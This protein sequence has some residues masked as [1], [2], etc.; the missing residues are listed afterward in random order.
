MRRVLSWRRSVGTVLTLVGLAPG[1]LVV[2][3]Q[4]VLA[5]AAAAMEQDSGALPVLPQQMTGSAAGLPSLLPATQLPAVAN[6]SGG[7]RAEVQPPKGAVPQEDRTPDTTQADTPESKRLPGGVLRAEAADA[8]LLAVPSLVDVYP[9]QGYLVD[10][11]TPSLRAWGQSNNG[12]YAMSYSFKICDVESMSGTGCTS[13]GDVAGNKN[14]WTVP[15][16]KLAW[17]KQYWWT[18]TVRDSY[19]SSTTTS[20]VLTFT[21]GVRQPAITSNLA[22]SGVAG[23]EFN[24]QNGNYTSTFTDLEVATA[25]PPLSVVRTY[26]GLDPRTDGMFGPGWSTRWDMKIV[27]EVRGASTSALVTYPNGRQVRFRANGDGTFQPPPGTHATLAEQSGGTWRLMDKAS[28]NYRFDTSGRLTS[29]TDQRGRAQELTYDTGGKLTKVTSVGGRSLTFTWQADRVAS[30]SSDPIDGTALTWTYGYDA[31]RLTQVCAPV[32]AP[33]C[34]S[35]EYGNGSLYRSSVLNSDPFGYWRL[36]EAAGATSGEDLG[37][38]AGDLTYQGITLAQPGALAGTTDTAATFAA[39]SVVK[40]PSSTVPHLGDQLSV[41]TWFKTTQSGVIMA[42]GTAES[43]NLA[44][45]AMLYVGTDG[46]LRGSLDAVMTPI[47]SAG[48]VNDGQWHHVALTVAGQD[49]TLYLDGQQVG[50]MTGQVTA[51]RTYATLGN[52]VT[53]PAKSPAVPSTVQAFPFQGQL[54][55][56]A[57]YGKPL[58]AAEVQGHYAT[59]TGAPHKL[60]KTT[61]PSG[62]VWAVNTYDAKTDRIAT[63]TDSN[64]GTWKIGNIGVEQQYGEAQ[65]TVTDPDNNTLVYLYDAWRGYRIRGETDQLGHTTWH[66]YDQAGFLTKVIDRND[67]VH[68]IY[69]DKRGNTLGRKY[70][71]APG[72]CAIEFWSY[73]L[74]PDDPFDPRNDQV[75]AYRDGRSAGDTDNTYATKTEYNTYGEQT[76]Q[77][78]PATADFP[79][80]RSVSTAYTDGSEP[81]VGGGTTPAGLVK[82]KTDARGSQWSYRYTAAGDLAEQTDPEAL[83]TKLDYD[84]IGRLIASTRIS[85][86]FPNG[87]KTTFTYDGRGRP[88]TST[89]PGVKNEISN[90]THTAQTRITYDPDGS[91]LTQTIADLTGG[92]AE[93]ATTY[94]YD[95]HGRQNS[96][97]DAEGGVARQEWNHRGWPIRTTD[98]RGTVIEQS[99]SKRG[100]LTTQTL[101][102]WTG[103]PVNPQPATDVVLETRGYD[104]AGRLTSSVDVMGRKTTNVYWMDNR[105]KQQLADDAKLNG[106]TTPRDVVVKAEEYDPAGNLVEQT[107]GGGLTTT[108]FDYDAASRLT[109]QILDPGALARTTAFAYDANGNVTQSTLTAAGTSRTE[110]TSYAYNK[111]NQTTKETIENGAQDL[112]STTGYDDRGLIVS[113]T[114][115]RGNADGANAVD[116]TATL[117]YDILDRLVETI[118]PQVQVDKNGTTGQARPAAKV[119]Y[120]TV[121]NQTHQSDAEGRTV[122]STFDK[123]GRLTSSIAP[124]YTPPGG[125]AI[126]STVRHAY[127]AAGQRKNTTDPR[128][129]VTTFDY[130]Q[131]GRQVRV[132]D[133][134]PDGQNAGTWVTEYDLA[135][136][137]LAGVDP[138]GARS[139]ATY[140]DLGRQITATQIERKPATA[141]YTTAMEYDDAGRLVK[142][143]APG[144]KV[145]SFTVNAAS[146]VTATTDPAPSTTTMAYDLAGRLVKTTDANG[147]AT[148]AEYDLAGRKIA[149][150]DL[151]AT[152]TV[153]RTFGYGYDAVGNPISATSP[154]GHVT[155]QTF[156][157]LGRP[158]SLIEPVSASEWITTSFGYDATSART[159]LTDGRGNATWTGYN[160]LG[161]VET[162]TEPITSAHPDPADRTWTHLYDAAG[163]Q[164]ATVQP[165]GVR[166]DRAFNH[167]GRVT[168]ETGVGGGAASAERTLGYDPAGRP[169]TAGDLTVDYNDRGLPLK[170]SRGTTQETAYAYDALGNPT[171]RIDAAGT[172]TF[173]YDTANRLATATDPVTGRT[174]TYGYDPASR[175]KTVSATS[176]QA[177]TQSFD[178]DA[179]YRLT[180]HTLKNGSGTQLAKIIYGW[181]KDDNL[182]T[183]TTTGTAGAGTNTYAYDHAGRL[184]SWTA[185]GG[186]TTAYEWDAAGNR[187]RAGNATFTYDER[188]RLTSGD[189]TDYS[190]TPRGTL[191]SQTKNSTTTQYTFDAFDRLI[192]D[193]DS[194]YSY[195]ALDRVTS[196]IRGTAKQ[197]FAYSGLGN[198]LAAI[199]G[200]GGA[201]QARY[202]RD[203]AGALLGLQEG[204]SAAVAALSDLHGD[205]VATFTS[206]LQTSAAYDPFGTVTAQT[207]AK[208]QLGYQGEYTDPDTGKVNMHARWYQP[209]SGTFTSRDTATLTPNPSVQANRYT[210]ANASPLTGT[211]PT[212][213]ATASIGS[214][215]YT[216]GIDHQSAGDVYAQYGIVLGGCGGSGL[217]I[218]SCKSIG[219][220][221]GGA[222]GCTTYGDCGAAI[223]DPSWIE[224]VEW[225]PGFSVEEAKRIGVMENGRPAPRGYWKEKGEVR[226]AYMV[227]YVMGMSDKDLAE[228]WSTLGSSG[229]KNAWAAPSSAGKATPAKSGCYAWKGVP[230]CI[231]KGHYDI[232]V[233]AMKYGTKNGP[234]WTTKMA[235][236]YAYLK[237]KGD[238]KGAQAYVEKFKK[239]FISAYKNTIK[240]AAKMFSIPPYLLAGILY[241]EAGG[242]PTAADTLATAWRDGVIGRFT[243]KRDWTT[244][245]GVGSINMANAAR[246]LGYTPSQMTD[247]QYNFLRATIRDHNVNI[248]TVAAY[249]AYIKTGWPAPWSSPTVQRR[250]AY[251]YNGSGAKAEEY[252]D[253]YMGYLPIAKG[254]L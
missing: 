122:V 140:D 64:G 58:T 45:G 68:D 77:T 179:M 182:T 244:T 153:L 176:G 75:T 209:G 50:T 224:A 112:V 131:L 137:K 7:W 135:G 170:V 203:P 248:F 104:P 166:I 212:G 33:N 216:P 120:D 235:A 70:C 210:Y 23:Q 211:D 6:A 11:L 226:E 81:A 180:G 54:D 134:A 246:A 79:S 237:A 184:T 161:L 163:N 162:V 87:A 1:L 17:G 175:L 193:S 223:V 217:Y 190:Y 144:N 105:L 158:T 231:T 159:R 86:A 92:E 32:A 28:T 74:N 76:N 94:T 141:A 46:K 98:A 124:Q 38:G 228:L 72:E 49:Q 3:G 177:G 25:G 47:T 34:T 251:E 227:A 249:M 192:A 206:S 229:L 10:S 239:A 65:V 89:V 156:D 154:E 63:H 132:T 85:Q 102:G 129:Y 147:N 201:V 245:F 16:G 213:H 116:Y 164:V 189:G 150:K 80:G 233:A 73:Y 60:T 39:G 196:R 146:E 238:K 149:T 101:K 125:S 44:R 30:I 43:S 241:A 107:T 230:G 187:T 215:S 5:A 118:A 110:T 113:T 191:A 133:P 41:E 208:T 99:Y 128:G 27:K 145:T 126:T 250:V 19:D 204:T 253:R 232:L 88:L 24:Q 109:A 185:P 119:G 234:E 136:E 169:T 114:D 22:N 243:G 214:S 160:S 117:R 13:S 29:I 103:S 83:V 155:K 40:L 171:Q 205:L 69:Q 199:A 100:E 15:A 236:H 52:G 2:Q 188:N 12:N 9:K 139:Q 62:R 178:Y 8:A 195:D 106:S 82:T 221:G 111:L 95:D 197:S 37:T 151:N 56:V 252:A 90:V 198:D 96:V 219:D 240:A 138:T 247:V 181:D 202:A 167:L 254:L 157:A 143:T 53:D 61:L 66:E 14:T 31:G 242:K 130:D 222:I 142:Q 18:V 26:N 220:A 174:L 84:P 173:T 93:R 20:P 194:L 115:P 121:G 78:T 4:P 42:A 71:R 200:S 108:V 183:K 225:D 55:E 59:R 36:G 207:G 51:W 67:I 186:A 148:V 152:G 91:P 123:A 21:T 48:A 165:G 172:A 97:T 218:G 168:K 35:Y 127:D 57:L